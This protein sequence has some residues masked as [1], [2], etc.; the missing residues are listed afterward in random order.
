M[1]K[2]SRNQNKSKPDNPF[3]GCLVGCSGIFAIAL[4]FVPFSFPNSTI[5]PFILSFYVAIP[6][7][8]I[9]FAIYKHITTQK[10]NT[11]LIDDSLQGRLS[12]LETASDLYTVVRNYTGRQE[13]SPKDV[14]LFLSDTLQLSQTQHTGNTSQLYNLQYT[15]GDK[16]KQVES[17]LFKLN[18][19]EQEYQ[20]QGKEAPTFILE[21]LEL[22]NQQITSLENSL[23]QVRS[24]LARLNAAYKV[25]KEKLLTLSDTERDLELIQEL[26][27]NEKIIS[28]IQLKANNEIEASFS[29][30]KSEILRLDRV[31]YQAVDL[32]IR[33]RLAKTLL[34]SDNSVETLEQVIHHVIEETQ[35]LFDV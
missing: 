12:A 25:C 9:L 10:T 28:Q 30:I 15:I 26:K 6:T 7:S 22:A 2:K 11:E 3:S 13:I 32:G 1:D 34:S 8:A 16:L 17:T 31:L 35:P 23:E 21:G 33:D 29:Q 4:F 24:H 14:R 18:Q 5:Y 27:D 20:Q 19:R